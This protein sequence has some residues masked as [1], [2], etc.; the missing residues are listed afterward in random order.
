MDCKIPFHYILEENY[1]TIQKSIWPANHNAAETL[2]F[3]IKTFI[4]K[5][6]SKFF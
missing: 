2:S 5:R 6:K 4:A 3:A 1:F